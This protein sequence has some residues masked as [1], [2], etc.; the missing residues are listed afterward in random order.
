MQNLLKV[1]RWSVEKS[2]GKQCLSKCTRQENAVEISYSKFP[3][4]M[5]L[6]MEDAI[7]LIK[8]LSISCDPGKPKRPLLDSL[9]PNLCPVFD[10]ITIE[11]LEVNATFTA[12][13]LLKK[14]NLTKDQHEQLMAYSSDN[15]VKINA[16]IDSPYISKYQMDEVWDSS[17][18][19]FFFF[20]VMSV[21]T[22]IANIGGML[23]LC[24]GFSFISLVEVFFFASKFLFC[25]FLTKD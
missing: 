1:G 5:F 9:Y 22:F 3:N 24:I 10:Q 15:L 8:K 19:V 7:K 2:S 14:L 17:N 20:Q 11:D 6:N 23:G 25:K 18:K 13:H 21:S 4:Q 12:R 16:F